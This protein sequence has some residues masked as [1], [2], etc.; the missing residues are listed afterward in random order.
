MVA[1]KISKFHFP[2][3]GTSFFLLLLLLVLVASPIFNFMLRNYA[4]ANFSFGGDET[5][6]IYVLRSESTVQYLKKMNLDATKYDAALEDMRKQ[7]KNQNYHTTIISKEELTKLGSNDTLFVIDSIALNA[8]ETATITNFVSNG[9]SLVFNSYAGFSDSNGS[10]NGA[11]F[12]TKIT[13]LARDPYIHTLKKQTGIFVTPKVFSPISNYVKE[14]PLLSAIF[15]D[16]IPLFQTPSFLKPDLMY[17]DWSQ[18][19]PPVIDHVVLPSDFSGALWHGSFGK[20]SWIYFNFP[21][22]MFSSSAADTD[23]F[24]S[25]FHGIADFA[26]NGVAVRLHPYL[27]GKNPVFISQDTE[28]RFENAEGFSNLVRKLQI[29]ST[30]FCVANLAE[31]NS[32]VTQDLGKNPF[33]EVGSHSYTHGD[34]LASDEDELNHEILDSKNVLEKISSSKITGFRPPREEINDEIA[35]KLVESGYKYTME[36]N[37]NHLYPSIVRDDLVVISRVGTDD[38]AYFSN[39]TFDQEFILHKIMKEASFINALDGIYTLS[40]HTHLF[41]DPHNMGLLES[42]LTNLKKSNQVDFRQGRDIAERIKTVSMIDISVSRSDK[43]YKVS[44]LNNNKKSVETTVF[45]L[46]WPRFGAIKSIKSDTTGVKFSSVDFPQ[47]RYSDITLYDLKPR[48][49]FTLFASY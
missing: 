11:S 29:P 28:F 5:S 36:K 17:T 43:N 37:K 13:G 27:N 2:V 12:V 42:I 3:Y 40:V 44:V 45:R 46:Y 38:Y 23:K 1:Q 26:I 35:Q 20:G 48:K 32:A 30:T 24:L 16:D 4:P 47:E 15:Y 14:A 7:L 33:I 10:W 34:L 49:Q 39:Y 18:Y 31:M 25:I 8:Q 21:S 41:S 19:A 9:G 22:Y 6:K